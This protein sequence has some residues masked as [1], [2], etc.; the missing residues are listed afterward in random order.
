VNHWGWQVGARL[1]T[2]PVAAEVFVRILATNEIGNWRPMLGL[3][4]GVTGAARFG[5]GDGLL[6]EAR[7]SM[8]EGISPLYLAV[9]AAPLSFTVWDT[10]H[11]SPLELQIGT[12][13][14]HTGRTMRLQLVLLNLGVAL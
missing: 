1:A 8:E 14:N 10:W 11:V 4:F 7:R 3:E 6:R 5:A 12:H 9:Y 2:G 13:L